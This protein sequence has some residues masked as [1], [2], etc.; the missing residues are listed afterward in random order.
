MESKSLTSFVRNVR[1][2]NSMQ[3]EDAFEFFKV[4]LVYFDLGLQNRDATDDRVTWDA[5]L[6]VLKH[7]R[8]H[9]P[10]DWPFGGRARRNLLGGTVFREPIVCQTVPCLVPNWTQPIVIG[11]HAEGDQ[12]TA[13]DL[14]IPAASKVELVYA[15]KEGGP[16]HRTE[17]FS[18]P[19]RGVAL[20]MYN[21]DS[22]IRNFAHCCFAYALQKRWPLF[23]STKNTILKNYDGRFKDIFHEVYESEYRKDFEDAGLRF[24]HRLI[25]DMVAQALKSSGGFV[26][27]CK[28]YDGDVQSDVVAQA[29][30][31][32]GLMTSVLVC[33]DGRTIEA[34]A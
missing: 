6:A 18:F 17:L 10:C 15:P 34:E 22:S 28:N 25:D 24:E 31:S 5:A 27:A 13:A 9:L 1:L 2:C 29:Y 3:F 19:E 33:P 23:L 11:R 32:L 8:L 30:G 7:N 14:D 26:W 12:Y 16:E 21:T 4:E 20:G